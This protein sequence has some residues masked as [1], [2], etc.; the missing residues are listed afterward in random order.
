MGLTNLT[1]LVK[2]PYGAT[3]A[4]K[5]QSKYASYNLPNSGGALAY[6]KKGNWYSSQGDAALGNDTQFWE[7]ARRLGT[8]PVNADGSTSPATGTSSTTS[9]GATATGTGASASGTGATGTTTTTPQGAIFKTVQDFMP[10]GWENDPLYQQSLKEAEQ[11]ANKYLAAK[12]LIG[13]G[14]E[15]EYRGNMRSTLLAD[16]SQRMYDQAVQNYGAYNAQQL[17]EALR[18]ERQGNTTWSRIMEVL[19]TYLNQNPIGSATQGATKA[20]DMAGG[21]GQAISALIA[22]TGTPGAVVMPNTQ[23]NY[24]GSMG[25]QAY[26]NSMLSIFANMLPYLGNLFGGK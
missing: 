24:S 25:S 16:Q 10:A 13:S 26:D 23:P 2:P 6:R 21:L 9:G 22:Q 15:D 12:G 4:P 14:A 20:A 8:N 7:Y 11:G 17:Q 19:N 3:K 5:Y 1:Q 18:L